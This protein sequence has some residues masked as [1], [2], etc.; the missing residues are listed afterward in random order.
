[1]K[2]AGLPFGKDKG[3]ITVETLSPTKGD[4]GNAEEIDFDLG[5]DSL[6][7][8]KKSQLTIRVTYFYELRIPIINWVFF[9]SWLAGMAGIGLTGLNPW[10]PQVRIGF[11]TR[12]EPNAAVR[13]AGELAKMDKAAP[14]CEF[15][16]LKK[17]H[18]AA[19]TAQGAA[20]GKWYLPLVT[21]YTIRMQSNPFV[22]FA[23]TNPADACK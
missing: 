6:D 13:M 4:F 20:I 3:L 22:K 11:V 9:E 15:T 14:N 19:L 5:G 16:G 23:G 12:N 18:I 7:V 10:E 21:T 1:M 2:Q 8:R 17:S